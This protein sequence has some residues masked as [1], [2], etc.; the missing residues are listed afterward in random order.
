MGCFVLKNAGIKPAEVERQN[1][2]SE[3]KAAIQQLDKVRDHE[4]RSILV[5]KLNGL[6]LTHQLRM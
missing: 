2:I 1:R 4:A 3:L 6:M 5:N